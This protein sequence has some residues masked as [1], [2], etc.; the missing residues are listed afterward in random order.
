MQW[1]SVTFGGFLFHSAHECQGQGVMSCGQCLA[2]GPH[3]AWC[4]E[5]VSDLGNTLSHPL[6][7]DHRWDTPVHS[8]EPWKSFLVRFL[9]MRNAFW[10]RL[11]II[12]KLIPCLNVQSVIYFI[13][14]LFWEF[15]RQIDN[16]IKVLSILC[17]GMS[18]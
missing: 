7:S 15:K 16:S 17:K 9:Y 11:W 10:E 14:L 4:A 13:Y 5:E 3:C 8:M 2:A 12:W 1:K 6:R 18:S